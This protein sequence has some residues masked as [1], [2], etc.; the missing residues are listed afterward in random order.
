MDTIILSTFALLSFG[1][2]YVYLFQHD[3]AAKWDNSRR[4]VLGQ[5]AVERDARW[6]NRA[7]LRGVMSIA[8]GVLLLAI[9]LHII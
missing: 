7:R 5:E 2:G 9:M 3:L 6:R 1:I 4:Q 8:V